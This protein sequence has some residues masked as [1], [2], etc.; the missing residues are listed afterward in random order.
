M[1]NSRNIKGQIVACISCTKYVTYNKNYK[2]LTS[3]LY[4]IAARNN[5]ESKFSLSTILESSNYFHTD[6][7]IGSKN[8][9]EINKITSE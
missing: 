4:S 1:Q 7:A 9:V 2:R 6:A 3:D 8:N 5:E